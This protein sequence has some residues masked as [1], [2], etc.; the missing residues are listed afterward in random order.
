VDLAHI[1]RELW[2]RK[3]LVACAGLLA[4]AIAIATTFRVSLVPPSIEKKNRE[5][6]AAQT[7]VLVDSPKSP[8]ADLGRSFEAATDRAAVYGPLMSSTPVKKEIARRVGIA[9]GQIITGGVTPDSNDAPPETRAN[10][11]AREDGLY[12]LRVST[13]SE[14]PLLSIAAQGPSAEAAIKLAD[15]AAVGLRDYIDKLQVEQA[16]PEARRVKVRQLGGAT[17]GVI[18]SGTNV[19][20]GLLA[21]VALFTGFS[22]MILFGSNVAAAWRRADQ[23]ERGRAGASPNGHVQPEHRSPVLMAPDRVT[24]RYADRH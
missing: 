20:I 6:G 4:L 22:L 15:A 11:I 24:S 5:V 3:A 2:K 12:R 8:V 1:L 17:G 7:Q 21:F 18:S 19:A 23:A 9:P 14:T 13:P 10:Q 16:V